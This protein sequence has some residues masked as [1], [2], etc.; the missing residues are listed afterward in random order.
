[1]T[2]SMI[3]NTTEIFKLL[4]DNTNF[5]IFI[6]LLSYS[7]LSLSEITQN[8]DKSKPT[9]S[10]R[11]NRMIEVGLIT[12]YDEKVRGVYAK[13]YKLNPEIL[14]PLPHFTTEQLTNI[15]DEEK[16]EIIDNLKQSLIAAANF[17]AS[18]LTQSKIALDSL[19][20]SI[21]EQ[22][23]NILIHP[24]YYLSFIP[25]SEDEYF[26]FQ[27]LSKNLEENLN[28]FIRKN[29]EGKAYELKNYL[30]LIQAGPTMNINQSNKK[31]A[32]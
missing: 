13:H 26:E 5:Q 18:T 20:S 23:E 28:N 3:M 1:M 7:D 8:I 12:S 11:L 19:G 22:A 10:R 31:D 30:A 9:L 21:N 16:K 29:R 6:Q 25:L 17:C 24:K 4:T 32:Q 2:D 14:K 27:R 15:S